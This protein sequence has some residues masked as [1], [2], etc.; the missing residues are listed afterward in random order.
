MRKIFD[1]PRFESGTPLYI[2]AFYE[3]LKFKIFVKNN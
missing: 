2:R 3:K 1:Q